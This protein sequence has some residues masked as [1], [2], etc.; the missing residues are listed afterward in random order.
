MT[1]TILITG[2]SAGIGAATA[3]LA[4]KRGHDVIL[5]Y[6]NDRTRADAVGADIR[7]LGQSA[8]VIQCDVADPTQIEAMYASIPKTTSL[9]LVN[10]AG[11]VDQAAPVAEMTAERVANMF[12]INVV[13][14][15]MVAKG[16]IQHMRNAG[17]TGHI[18]N[19]S[20]A[21]ARLGSANQYVDYAASKA[22]IDTFTIGLADEL[23]PEGI[24]VNAVRP[25]LIKT[26]IHAKG[27]QPDRLERLSNS[28]PLGRSG[29]AEE[30]AETI[31]WL[32]S[33]QASYVTRTLLDV[34]GG[35]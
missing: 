10:N 12:Q 13:G 8:Q 6:C 7:A 4:A 29:S 16:A 2:G 33:D 25:G 1:H 11:I 23:A 28:I 27:G 17:Q 31:L 24:R 18:V 19:L 32:L 14:A 3:R 35:R 26:D 22:A 15:F 5:T 30:V 9:H 34:A 20:S 21:A